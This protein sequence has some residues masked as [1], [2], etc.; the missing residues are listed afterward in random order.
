MESSEVK[1]DN[2]TCKGEKSVTRENLKKDL[3][4]EK[5]MK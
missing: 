5:R 4:G 2:T 3:S 1:W